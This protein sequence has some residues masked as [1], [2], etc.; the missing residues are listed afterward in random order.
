MDDMELS[1][2]FAPMVCKPMR[3]HIENEIRYNFVLCLREQGFIP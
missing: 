2:F 3:D 1:P